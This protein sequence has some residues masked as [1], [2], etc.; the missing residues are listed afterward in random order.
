MPDSTTSSTK[1]MVRNLYGMGFS[2]LSIGNKQ[3]AYPEEL[4]AQ[5]DCGLFAIM[6][7][8][9]TLISS[10]YLGRSKEHIDSFIN[11]CIAD[12]TLGK[13]Y[14]ITIDDNLVRNVITTGNMFVND[15][16]YDNG[17][18]PVA[19]IRFDVDADFFE[20]ETSTII[21]ANDVRFE[22]EFG[23]IKDGNRKNYTINESMTKLNNLAY[24]IDYTDFPKSDG[25][26]YSIVV[27]SFKVIVPDKF[28]VSKNTIVIHDILFEII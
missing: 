21:R 17:E 2:P 6:C 28:D 4:M 24:K 3:H 26:N 15:V 18:N 12:N 19:G 5:K 7:A 23:V 27:N 9:G 14:K 20:R 11:R 25:L 22:I 8:D 1:K 13:I 16:T 10:E